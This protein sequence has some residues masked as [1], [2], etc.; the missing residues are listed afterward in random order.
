MKNYKNMIPILLV[1]LMAVSILSTI[2]SASNKKEEYVNALTEARKAAK[3]GIVED[4][5]DNYQKA[6]E[7]NPS[8]DISVEVG[9][10]YVKQGWIS[11]AVSWGE[12]T[13]EQFPNEVSG[14]NFLMEQYI[15]LEDFEECF[16]LLDVVEAKDIKDKDVENL[17]DKIEYVYEY[18]FGYFDD[19]SV[20]SGGLCAVKEDDLWGY[21]NING[22]KVISPQFLWA[23]AFTTDEIA[24]IETVDGEY[25]Y[26]SEKGNKKVV[27]QNLEKCVDLGISVENVLPASDNGDYSYYNQ[28]FEKLTDKTYTYASA[29][30]GGIAAVC[31]IDTWY[32]INSSEKK[33]GESHDAII[34]D[35]KG[36]VFRNDRAFVKDDGKVYMVDEKGKRVGEKEF[37]DAKLFLQADSYAAIKIGNKWGFIDR[38]GKIIIE[39]QFTDARSFSNGF[40][41]V[42]Q[43]GLWGFID[44]TGKMVIDCRFK[45]VRD[46]NDGG[47]V[48]VYIEGR[49]QL[50]KL[51]KYNYK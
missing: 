8:V 16:K 18:E 43:N 36:I 31:E 25:Y 6:M 28:D 34:A 15:A 35:E 32:L 37:D 7:L 19:V 44:E 24:P 14:Y 30:N 40:A 17:A 10:L 29:M 49:W 3:L 4:A 27:V 26:I 20:F 41:A 23:G 11:E 47:N 50:L 46:F 1:V 38:D 45:D 21:V 51:I 33:I 13:V 39:P 12:K 22:K 5:V 42:K 9:E 48:F 2:M